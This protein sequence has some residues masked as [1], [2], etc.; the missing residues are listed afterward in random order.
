MSTNVTLLDLSTRTELRYL[1]ALTAAFRAGAGD[2]P[3]FLAGATA[4]D[5]LL[6]YAHGIDPGR[7]TRDADFALM[8]PD[9]AAFEALRLRLLDGGRFVQNGRTAHKLIFD[10]VLDVD[11]ISAI[12]APADR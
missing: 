1:A 12:S 5:L 8:V 3:F 11:L 9:W 6:Y 2:T 7:D 10:G 4:R